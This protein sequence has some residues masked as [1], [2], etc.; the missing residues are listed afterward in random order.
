M[1]TE[2]V[3]NVKNVGGYDFGV[4]IA[5]LLPGFVFLWA[6]LLSFPG[7]AS[8]LVSPSAGSPE[9]VP[10]LPSVGGFLYS[11]LTS[12]ALG[13]ILSAL[14]WWIIDS[15]LSRM[16]IKDPDFDFSHLKKPEAASAF[17][18]LIENHYRYYQYYANTLMAILAGCL[19]YRASGHFV[20]WGVYAT[21]VFT[22]VVLFL[23]ARDALKKYYE[24]TKQVLP[25]KS[26]EE[27][28]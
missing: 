14:R 20:P 13:L 12:L 9:A 16:G 23:G 21:V 7:L 3:G 26:K 24:R 15:L 28:T 6:L 4:V 2:P 19:L 25:V 18:E 22:A 17:R 5:F 1:S 11:A 27:R 8:W 10:E